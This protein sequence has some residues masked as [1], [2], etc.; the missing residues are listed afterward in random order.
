MMNSQ[1]VFAGLGSREADYGRTEQRQRHDS[2][3]RTGGASGGG[4]SRDRRECT[5]LKMTSIL[6]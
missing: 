1:G 5:L 3:G 6:M 4:Y 2:G